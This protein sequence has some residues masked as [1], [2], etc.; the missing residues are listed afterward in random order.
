M[1]HNNEKLRPYAV[2]A[3][4]AA[5]AGSLLVAGAVTEHNPSE[6]AACPVPSD[7]SIET[8]TTMFDAPIVSPKLPETGKSS[9]YE[10]WQQNNNIATS[11]GLTLPNPTP[12]NDLEALDT[13]VASFQDFFGPAHDYLKKFGV[14]LSVARPGEMELRDDQIPTPADLEQATTKYQVRAAIEGFRAL[15]VE[16]FAAAGMKRLILAKNTGDWLGVALAADTSDT[17]MESIDSRADTTVLSTHEVIHLLDAK[18]C[19]GLAMIR[20]D[21]A[22]AAIAGQ[23]IYKE[24]EKSRAVT[25]TGKLGQLRN[26]LIEN[27]QSSPD[28]AK[29]CEKQAQALEVAREV[30]GYSNYGLTDAAEDKAEVGENLAYPSAYGQMLDRGMPKMRQKFLFLLARL[31]ERAPNVVRFMA[32]VGSHTQDSKDS[33]NLII[34]NC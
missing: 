23:D 22:Y 5:L 32:T 7:Q 27:E 20:N 29:A 15:P 8:V 18:E 9:E 1:F 33:Y 34:R 2:M 19:G 28:R 14:E 6:M 12:I 3:T 10:R 17:V 16:F 21:P 13:K 26:E 4:T 25:F 30:V 11:L 24:P 31:Y